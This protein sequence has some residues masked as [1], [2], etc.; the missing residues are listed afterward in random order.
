MADEL[1]PGASPQTIAAHALG[2]MRA[3]P[4]EAGG[5]GPREPQDAPAPESG[6]DAPDES[7]PSV[8][9]APQ[10]D[11]EP[12]APSV[13]PPASWTK[14]EKEAFAA[15]PPD[16]QQTIAD[17][18]RERTKTYRQSQ[19]EAA[20]A[21]KEREG[22]AADRQ[23]YADNLA[24]IIE[25]TKLL[26]PILAAGPPD[27]KLA[28]EN[29]AEY[30]A[31]Q[32]DYDHRVKHL[33]ALS[34]EHNR[35]S[36]QA[37]GEAQVKMVDTLRNDDELGLRDDKKWEAFNSKV[38]RYLISQGVP[39]QRI[40]RASNAFEIK[41]AWKAMQWDEHVAQKK[42]I[43]AKKV[44]PAPKRVVAP[45]AGDDGGSNPR[46]EAVLKAATRSG[47]SRRQADAILAHLRANPNPS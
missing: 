18:E 40:Q 43:E 22:I 45:N 38:T 41:T 28:A 26:D 2:I 44:T 10:A 21:R 24:A 30:V 47:N 23:R 14:A 11:P 32:A 29:P 6:D 13:E 35:V 19:D 3:N 15:L 9:D 46:S 17:R 20:A 25:R 5:D 12:P 34:A 1:N 4:A 39:A 16:K 8:E 33:N 7:P 42:A 36:E 31:K 37:L 27:P